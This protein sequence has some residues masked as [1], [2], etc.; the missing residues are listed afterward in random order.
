MKALLSLITA[1]VSAELRDPVIH[2]VAW[3]YREASTGP[4]Q[5][6]VQSGMVS[7]LLREL[8]LSFR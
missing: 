7:V 1:I 6:A 4:E 5:W 2:P 3:K 8:G